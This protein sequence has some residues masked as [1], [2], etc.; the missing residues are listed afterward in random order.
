MVS[1][2]KLK[3]LGIIIPTLDIAKATEIHMKSLE[4]PTEEDDGIKFAQTDAD[5][6]PEDARLIQT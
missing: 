6:K 5:I 3:Q 4:S 1:S 2:T